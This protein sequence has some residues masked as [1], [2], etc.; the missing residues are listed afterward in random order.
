MPLS[1]LVDV[2]TTIV[3]GFLGTGKTTS[4]LNW[5]RTARPEHERWAIL[6][7]EFGEV[8]IDGATLGADGYAVAEV[9]GGCICCTAGVPMRASLIRLLRE[10]RPDRLFIEPTG[11]A[12]P[13]QIVDTLRGPR[14]SEA[15]SLRAVITLVD[16]KHFANPR[17]RDNPT[18]IDQLTI[19]DVLVA[20][21]TDLCTDEELAGFL[22]GAAALYPPKVAVART[23]EGRLDPAWLELAAGPDR[24]ARGP[25]QHDH[26]HVHALEGPG[27]ADHADGEVATCGWIF[28]AEQTWDQGRLQEALQ[29]LVR[30]SEV[31]PGGVL[32]LK[33]VFRT[34]RVWQLV[35]ASASQIRFDPI[36]YRRDSRVEVICPATPAPDWD[37]VE[38]IL[39]E[40][41]I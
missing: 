31:L 10:E 35:N 18:Y 19:A 29:Q 41:C 16:P 5:F 11:L 14:L 34:Q 32:R 28:P 9:P 21:R 36:N 6:V 37:G 3:T 15:L 2:P 13:A 38:R 25:V 4:I 33:G 40:A 7:N 26:G 39:H 23:T 12:V 24:V 8:G 20:N 30:P 1:P 17:Y 27:R 22:A